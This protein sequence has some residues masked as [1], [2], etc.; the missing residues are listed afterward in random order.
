MI[1]SSEHTLTCSWDERYNHETGSADAG[2]K[3]STQLQRHRAEQAS[4]IWPRL[5]TRTPFVKCWAR[6]LARITL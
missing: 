3:P 2:R 6:L 1:G 4:H 5:N